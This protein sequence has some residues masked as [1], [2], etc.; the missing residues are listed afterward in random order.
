MII[1]SRKQLNSRKRQNYIT[2]IGTYNKKHLD[3][4]MKRGTEGHQQNSFTA[5]TT[6]CMCCKGS[7]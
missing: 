4:N 1:V 2:A 3:K 6:Q 7:R 5:I